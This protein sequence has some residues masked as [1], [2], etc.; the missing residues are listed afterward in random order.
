MRID[1]QSWLRA[2]VW[3]GLGL[4]I[5]AGV[6]LF[7]GWVV[8]PIEF[9]DAEPSVMEERFQ[10]DY[11][12]MIATVYAEDND[13]STARRRLR[14]L[15]KEETGRWV[16]GLAVDRILNRES[17]TEILPLVKLANDLGYFSPIMEPYIPV[18]ESG[19]ES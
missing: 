3:I 6:G 14:G 19:Q 5:G 13:L 9:S 2:V 16:L 8:W 1:R 18:I 15:G 7:L 12:L 17:E 4:I 10:A 11:T